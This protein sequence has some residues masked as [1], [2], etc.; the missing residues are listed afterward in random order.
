MN[1]LRWGK[2]YWSDWAD[3]PAL[4]LCSLAAQGLWMR[5]LCLAAQGTPYGHV[6]VN[7]KPPSMVDLAKLIRPRPRIA[8]VERMVA[9]LIR[10]GVVERDVCGCLVSRRME[11]DGKLAKVRSEAARRMHAGRSRDS[12]ETPTGSH[13][14]GD[15]Y[16][17]EAA[18]KADN[19]SGLHMQN[20]SEAGDF[21]STESHTKESQKDSPR[22]PP[23]GARARDRMNGGGRKESRNA[24]NDMLAEEL[25]YGDADD[26]HS[27]GAPVVPFTRRIVSG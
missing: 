6:T 8:F 2:F 10:N 3:D 24:N 13:S 26:S 18:E 7:G 16:H 1:K 9:E 4:A 23:R 27:G 14:E 11:H 21:A 22:S 17:L 5:L 12:C 19:G 25:G 15:S 20:V